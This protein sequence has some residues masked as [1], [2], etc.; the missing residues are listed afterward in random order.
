MVA[1]YPEFSL[2]PFSPGGVPWVCTV[3]FGGGGVFTWSDLSLDP[4]WLPNLAIHCGW[5]AYNHS[6]GARDAGSPTTCLGR[7][8][9]VESA[10]IKWET[11]PPYKS[12]FNQDRVKKTPNTNLWPIHMR[13]HTHTSSLESFFTGIQFLLVLST[14]FQNSASFSKATASI[15]SNKRVILMGLCL[16]SVIPHQGQ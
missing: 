12:R 1:Q 10:R 2:L 7:L 8:T 5:P 9:K 16:S 15:A 4:V 13:A 3:W 14:H 11:P 6:M